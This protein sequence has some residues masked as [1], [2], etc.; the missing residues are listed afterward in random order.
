MK[1]S[2]HGAERYRGTTTIIPAL[3]FKS[4]S[5]YRWEDNVTWDSA[6]K[7]LVI[8]ASW[9][10][11]TDGKS[12]HVYTLRLT[13]EDISSLIRLLGHAGSATDAKLLRDHLGKDIPA[14]V[15][16]LS[17]ATGAAPTPLP[18]DETK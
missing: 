5:K 12:H 8:K 18:E 14:I 7:E 15:K 11:S 13:L 6:S 3:S 1:I 2:R 17:C 4:G 9:V 16:L 10:R